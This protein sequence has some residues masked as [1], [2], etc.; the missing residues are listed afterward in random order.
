MEIVVK[1]NQVEVSLQTPQ[2]PLP[3]TMLAVA[4]LKGGIQE[5]EWG[6]KDSAAGATQSPP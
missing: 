4:S 6:G 5:G 2:R 1:H 3:N